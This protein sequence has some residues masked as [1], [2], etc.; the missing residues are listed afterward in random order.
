[1]T[2]T[3]A[4]SLKANGHFSIAGKDNDQTTVSSWRESGRQFRESVSVDHVSPAK[5]EVACPQTKRNET[6]VLSRRPGG[7]NAAVV[8]AILGAVFAAVYLTGAGGGYD[9]VPRGG[10]DHPVSGGSTTTPTT[11][12]TTTTSVAFI[13][14]SMLYFNDFPRFFE[15]I[16]GGGGSVVRQD[17]CLHGG[18]SIGSLLL[19]GNLMHPQFE[20]TEAIIQVNDAGGH[21]PLHDYGA[22]TVPQLLLGRDDRLV[23]PGYPV[24]PP[25]GTDAYNSNPCR[26][27]LA[28]REY[29]IE[30]FGNESYIPRGG[31][32][33]GWG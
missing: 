31:G 20:T 14:N 32:G 10:G 22:C 30:K 11:T 29:A 27:D 17:S 3:E 7:A 4:T 5:T 24:A 15:E 8:A 6:Q 13:G 19:E 33:G 9:L 2:A 25:P 23:D 18:A 28:Y 12:T 21:A 26:T 16:S 1:M